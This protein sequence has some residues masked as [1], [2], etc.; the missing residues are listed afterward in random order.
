[1]GEKMPTAEVERVI[2]EDFET[3]EDCENFCNETEEIND[4]WYDCDE[5]EV[6]EVDEARGRSRQIKIINASIS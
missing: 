1:M 4:V 6:A 5:D 2:N 3:F